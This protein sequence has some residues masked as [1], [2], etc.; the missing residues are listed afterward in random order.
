M[1][2]L[3]TAI[4]ICSLSVLSMVVSSAYADSSTVRFFS[5]IKG[6]Q[7]FW[8]DISDKTA[9]VTVQTQDVDAQG[10]CPD[11]NG[12]V[13]GAVFKKSYFVVDGAG[14]DP[15]VDLILSSGY[16]K[17]CT[18]YLRSPPSGLK[19]YA[20]GQKFCLNQTTH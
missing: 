5:E 18:G 3:L 16:F 1:K 17:S 8:C 12:T 11:G 10:F 19:E 2:K 13:S 20:A 6:K 9:T 4:S 14:I 15:H 7:Y